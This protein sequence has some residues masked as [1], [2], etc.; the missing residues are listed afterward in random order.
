MFKITLEYWNLLVPDIYSSSSTLDTTAAFAFG[1][2]VD[3]PNRKGMYL[4]VLSRLRL[5]MISRMAKPEEVRLL[6][7]CLLPP[8]RNGMHL[9]GLSLL[10]LLMISR[11]AKPEEVRPLGCSLQVK[12]PRCREIWNSSLVFAC[13]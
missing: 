1:G 12:R 4:E 5:L 6:D 3:A 10:C 9:K 8:D 11:M 7:F 13:S 2:A